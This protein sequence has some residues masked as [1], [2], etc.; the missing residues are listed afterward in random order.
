YFMRL[1][2]VIAV[3]CGLA[4]TIAGC[5]STGGAVPA[6]SLANSS[7]VPRFM[8]YRHTPALPPPHKHA[9]TA[10]MRAKARSGGW[11]EISAKSPFSQGPGT[12][13]LMTDGTVMVQDSCTPN[14]YAL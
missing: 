3:W 8:S 6:N 7:N 13:M 14:W 4:A 10:Q 2:R 12:E 11:Q 9:I 5:S 1:F